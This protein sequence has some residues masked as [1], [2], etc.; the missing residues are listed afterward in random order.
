MAAYMRGIDVQG[1]KGD[2]SALFINS[3]T[4]KPQP[5]EGQAL[6]RI[7]AF[8][9]N[10]MDIIQR[11]GFYPLPAQAP[12]TLGVEFS[13]TIESFGPGDH[14]NF[15][16]GNDVIGLAYG[17][18]YAE[19]IVV[20]TRMLLHKPSFI[21]W[22]VGAG[23]PE[24]WITATQA[25]HLV[26]D[27]TKGKTILWHA[28]ASG[29]SIAGIQLSRLAG[30]TKIFA[31]AGS[32][33]KCD[34][35]TKELGVTAAF[36]YK[37]QNWAEEIIKHTDGNGVDYIVDFVGGSYFQQNLSAAT[38]DGRIVILGT[39]GGDKAPEVDISQI[40]YKRLRVE[41][42]TL[43]SRD[44]EY[45]GRL[46]DKLEE[47]LPHFEAGRLKVHI[48]KVFPWEKVREAHDHIEESRNVGKVICIIS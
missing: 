42:S 41:G 21:D 25:L 35:I 37:T 40:L 30:A 31:T 26:L 15:E 2:S 3:K 10:R 7:R 43:R 5:A 1:G 32:K 45:Q 38:R 27:F 22:V 14:S 24:T 36:N 48:D 28:G 33:E 12:T 6:V 17:G 39:L 4:P 18:A 23:I 44:E 16:M 8:G 47:Y 46:R 34:F 20:S 11:Q 9:I 19:Y 13:G 29:V